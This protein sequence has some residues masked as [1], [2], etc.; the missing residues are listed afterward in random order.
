MHDCVD[1]S[2]IS[3]H[4]VGGI[5]VNYFNLQLFLIDDEIVEACSSID[6]I[7]ILLTAV[8]KT[9]SEDSPFRRHPTECH[10]DSNAQLGEEIVVCPFIAVKP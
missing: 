9:S 2:N 1:T 3:N 8:V 7:G 5:H 6:N 4:F 10:L